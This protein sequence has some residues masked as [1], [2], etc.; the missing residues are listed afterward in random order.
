MNLN[1]GK[2]LKMKFFK[3][4]VLSIAVSASMISCAAVA[5]KTITNT[6][7]EDIADSA[8]WQSSKS[9]KSLL[10]ATLE[11]DGLAVFNSKGQQIQHIESN[12]IVGVDVRYNM[13]AENGKKIDVAAAVLVDEGAFSFY[14]INENNQ[15]PLKKIGQFSASIKVEG[16]CLAKNLT[17]GVLYANG[18]S[19]DGDWVQFKLNYDG[20][21]ITSALQSKGKALPVR[22]T[23][24]GGKLSACVVDDETST[25]YLAEQNIGVWQYGADPENVKDRT[26]LDVAKPIGHISEVESIDI[27]YQQNGKGLIIIADESEGFLLYDRESKVYLNQFS[28]EGVEEAKLVT[29][30]N[31]GL[32][33]GNTELDEPI[34]QTLSFKELTE[35]ALNNIAGY[36][37]GKWINN[38][39]L[40]TS[41]VALVK[42]SGETEQ[43]NKSGD[44]ADDPAL[45]FDKNN[46]EKSLII[47]TNKK[48]GLL[49]YDL[50]GAE[51]QFIKGNEVNNVDIRQSIKGNDGRFY[52]IAAASNR[53]LNTIAL[54]TISNQSFKKPMSV[55]EV[56]GKNRH[57]EAPELASEMSKIYGL[58]MGQ[59]PEGVPYVFINDKSGLIEQ[60]RISVNDGKATGALVRTLSVATQP[61][62][63]V[64]DDKTQTL[65]VGEENA[66][67]WSFDAS[68][69]GSTEATLFAAIDGENIVADIEGITLYQ[70]ETQNLLLASIQGNNTYAVFDLNNGGA[71]MKNFAV[72]GDDSKGVDGASDT[73]GI[74]ATSFN[75]GPAYPKGIFLVQD[76]YNLSEQYKPLNQNFKIVDW[77]DIDM[78]LNK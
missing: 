25:L 1:N 4:S 55:L 28:I 72:I 50:K 32:W 33:I 8:H 67:I 49:A 78:V 77:R 23:H 60:W 29:V 21:T 73:D 54:Y 34:Y 63:C 70:T 18:F 48:G 14:E 15:Q 65:Y 6:S 45:W 22:H 19:D 7:Y 38:S 42:A 16:M 3:I 56:I 35:I 53:E 37:P 17:T 30:S 24:V 51:I 5:E 20:K 26:L 66:A 75:F 47:A 41:H 46:P 36:S 57:E 59:S 58:C 68:E 9:N 52:D 12:E 69:S 64:V 71:Y 74:H 43:V 13:I 76:W 31:K 61:E 62:G 40:K 27:A 10:I 44:A 39:E 11:G 2:G